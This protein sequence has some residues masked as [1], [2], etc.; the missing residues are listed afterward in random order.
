VE[1]TGMKPGATVQ[2]ETLDKI[3][4]NAMAACDAVGRPASPSRSQTQSLRKVGAGT[5]VE[6]FTVNDRGNYI[7]EGSIEPWSVVLIKEL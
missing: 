5:K 7:L 3:H 2:I 6:I 1:L 4:G